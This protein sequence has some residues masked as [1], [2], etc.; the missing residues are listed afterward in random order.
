ML[1]S[2]RL[3]AML[4]LAP[5]TMYLL[6]TRHGRSRPEHHAPT[7]MARDRSF[8]EMSRTMGQNWKDPRRRPNASER[9]RI[10]LRAHGRC[11][12]CG[13]KLPPDYH[14]AHLIAYSNGG[15]TTTSQMEAWCPPCNLRLGSRDALNVSP[16]AL[17]QWQNK[18]LLPISERLL[19]SGNGTLAAA[20]GSGKTLFAGVVFLHLRYSGI[21]RL[22]V[23]VPNR[24]LVDQ[25]VVALGRL[26]IHLDNHPRDG[27]IEKTDCAG[28]V[29]T[30]QSLLHTTDAHIVRLED[31]PTLVIL[32]EVHHLG[33]DLSWGEAVRNMIGDASTN[34]NRGTAVLNM[35]GTLFRS[36]KKKRISTVRYKRI[37]LNGEEKIQAVADHSV[38]MKA[39]IGIELREPDLHAYSAQAQLVD[40]VA[41]KTIQS[42]IADLDETQY[43][44]VMTQAFMSPAWMEGFAREAVRIL[45]AQLI[46]VNY[47][48]PLKLLFITSSIL[49]ANVAERALNKVAGHVFART[50]TS[51]QPGALKILQ[52]FTAESH[53]CAI[54]AVRMITEG[55]DCPA[56]S[57]IAYATNI[58]S[59]LFISQMMARAMR[60]TDFERA[61]HRALPAKILIPD[62]DSMRS[63]FSSAIFNANPPLDEEDEN[64]DEFT[65]YHNPPKIPRFELLSLD[66]P[67]LSSVALIARGNTEIAA[68]ELEIASSWCHQ[69]GVPDT[70]SARVALMLREHTGQGR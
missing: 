16:I 12:R 40:V 53:P 17:R 9:R 8:C 15:A 30:Y 55:F 37:M 14:N 66:D 1:S 27:F 50:V 22:L 18:A 70:Y 34:S 67:K 21:Q 19:L 38:P 48:V 56:V 61:N 4:C 25:W 43:Q 3:S 11:Q 63:A 69:Y 62:H 42:D 39:L 29:V 32:D 58:T 44:S 5:E 51:E 31:E 64:A 60:L 28:L 7:L 24:V 33:T 45:Q 49:E 65:G 47:A 6:V 2:N 46:A 23:L 68:R 59:Q 20:P 41:Q 57:T 35:T 52:D 26:K 36:S 54:V 10:Y 13:A